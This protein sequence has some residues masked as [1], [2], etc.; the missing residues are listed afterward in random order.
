[1]N[2]LLAFLIVAALLLVTVTIHYTVLMRLTTFLEKEASKPRILI[3]IVMALFL[4]H[5][6]EI[7]VYAVFYY[8]ADS[9]ALSDVHSIKHETVFADSLY[10]ST[11]SFSS[12]GFS[13][14]QTNMV[15][16]LVAGF[17]AL[18]VLLLITWSASFTFLAMGKLW[19]CNSCQ[20]K[21]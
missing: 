5:A 15:V 8:F 3:L 1:M 20:L 13:N 12:L 9:S 4:A 21:T 11:L 18:N 2:Y 19:D 16:K 7:M 14:I 10:L 6:I 17:E